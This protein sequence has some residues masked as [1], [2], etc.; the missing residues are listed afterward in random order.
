LADALASHRTLAFLD[1]QANE[2]GAHGAECL[3]RAL[4]TNRSLAVLDLRGNCLDPRDW[5]RLATAWAANGT[6]A[7]RT[8]YQR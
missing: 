2:I 8:L 4:E 7:R 1:M 3:A 5:S 6:P